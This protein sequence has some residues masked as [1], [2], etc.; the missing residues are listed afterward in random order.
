MAVA[1]EAI[2][3]ISRNRHQEPGPE[4][5][6]AVACILCREPLPAEARQA[7]SE[8]VC[9]CMHALLCLSIG[10]TGSLWRCRAVH[11]LVPGRVSGVAYCPSLKRRRIRHAPN[12]G[13]SDPTSI[14]CHHC[15]CTRGAL[16]L[17]PV[18]V[19]VPGAGSDWH[20]SLISRVCPASCSARCA[21]SRHIALRSY[22]RS[23]GG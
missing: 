19:S 18:A 5:S 11:V 10:P 14:H 2:S 12:V 22:A 7:A 9:R 3:H 4:A 16:T 6:G 1:R 21:G 15:L 23:P 8:G 20:D 13:E 17:Q